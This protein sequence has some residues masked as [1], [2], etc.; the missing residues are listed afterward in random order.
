MTWYAV[1]TLCAAQHG[2][3]ERITL[4]NAGSFDAAI[5]QAGSEAEEYAQLLGG[6]D[7]G[8]R[9]AFSL[10]EVELREGSEL[11]SLIRESPLS[12]AEY[13]DRFFVEGTERQQHT[14]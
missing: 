9:Q 2:Y 8:L 1:R 3:E 4:W 5:E 14:P 11:F 7:L 6:Q 12:H 10:A 13:I